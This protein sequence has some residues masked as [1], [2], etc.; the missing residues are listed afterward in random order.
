MTSLQ[1]HDVIV[2]NMEE[3]TLHEEELDLAVELVKKEEVG[4]EKHEV[5]ELKVT[6]DEDPVTNGVDDGDQGTD[7]QLDAEQSNDSSKEAEEQDLMTKMIAKLKVLE[8]QNIEYVN[9][10]DNQKK[11]IEMLRR[12]VSSIRA[13]RISY[14]SF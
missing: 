7:N 11:V 2:S 8:L 13:M 14:P 9:E 10:A 5:A 1:S 3:V 12:E 4:D 6:D